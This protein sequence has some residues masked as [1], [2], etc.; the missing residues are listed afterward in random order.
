MT[1]VEDDH[2]MVRRPVRRRQSQGL[3]FDPDFGTTGVKGSCRRKM[4]SRSEHRCRSTKF[5][6]K[7]EIL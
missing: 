3:D 2:G 1:T 7:V 6:T 5:L 4:W